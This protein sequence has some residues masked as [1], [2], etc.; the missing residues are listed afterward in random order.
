VALRI[1]LK[2]GF[3][4][5]TPGVRCPAQESLALLMMRFLIQQLGQLLRQHIM[6]LASLF[7]DEGFDCLA[8]QSSII[9]RAGPY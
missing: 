6:V 3:S 9:A 8:E 5:V 7:S 1:D 4:S 2:D